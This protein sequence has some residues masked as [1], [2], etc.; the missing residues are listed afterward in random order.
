[1]ID[2][3][4]NLLTATILE[5]QEALSSYEITSRELV[6]LY[7]GRIDK[8]NHK[9]PELNAVIEINPDALRIAEQLDKERRKRNDKSRSLLYGIPILVK[10]NIATYGKMNT[11][12]GSFALLGSKVP[13]D[14]T[15]IDLLIRAGAIILGKTNLSE[16][17]NFRSYNVTRNGWS[18]RGNITRSAY[19]E[20]GETSGS[21][22]GSAVAVSIGLCS[23]ALGE[24]IDLCYIS[25]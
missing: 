13:R 22:S 10:D 4:L 5:L 23:V 6:Q 25:N 2:S 20:D 15:I 1:S 19:V 7:L 24:N 14:A 3:R 21:S 17:A 18:A 12:A 16:W 9:G 11:T 8:V